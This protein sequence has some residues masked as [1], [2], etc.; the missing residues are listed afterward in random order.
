MDANCDKID[1]L[2]LAVG[3]SKTER[4]ILTCLAEN[5]NKLVPQEDL[6]MILKGG[7]S[8]TIDSHIMAIRRKLKDNGLALI[9]RTVRGSGFVLSRGTLRSQ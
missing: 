4:A 2:E 3:L 6:L 7:S 5:M 8:H 9:V 1:E